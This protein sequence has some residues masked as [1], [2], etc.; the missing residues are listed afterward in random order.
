MPRLLFVH[1]HP[2]DETLTCGVTMAHH[3]ARGDEVHVLTC[4]LGE[5]G[6]VIP[7]G[8]AHLEGD[9]DDRL[10][11]YRHGELTRALCRVGAVMH[12]LGEDPGTG[13]LSR[14]RD[15]GMVGSPA[16]ARPE[17]FAAADLDVAGGLVADVMREVRPDVVVT[18]DAHGGYG[19]PDHVQTH[20]V[21]RRALELLDDT[22]RPGRVFEI[23]TPIG[24]AREDRAWLRGADPERLDTSA[25]WAEQELGADRPAAPSLVVPATDDPFAPSVVDDG[26]VTHAVVDGPARA[27][28]NDALRAHAT[29]VIVASE[30]VHA[31]SNLVAARTTGREGFRRVDPLTWET[32]GGA[33][34]PGEAG[35]LA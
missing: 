25:W 3:V 2:D 28:Q 27:V 23:L 32:L 6:E 9:P 17:A 20:R 33:V 21:T 1:A 14:Y 35:L 24:W 11:P 5:E 12:V 15:S 13:R 31:L 19:H 7:P 29:Q 34:E 4:T 10:A 16:A 22:D 26:R 30:D 18:Y 8:L